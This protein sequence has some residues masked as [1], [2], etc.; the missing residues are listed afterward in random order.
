MNSSAS[1]GGH[2]TSTT[3]LASRGGRSGQRQKH[4]KPLTLAGISGPLHEPG[5][6]SD[7]HAFSLLSASPWVLK[8]ASSS[9][10][11]LDTVRGTLDESCVPATGGFFDDNS[12]TDSIH[13]ELLGRSASSH[14]LNHEGENHSIV[15]DN[16]SPAV[17]NLH[18]RYRST[19]SWI[20]LTEISMNNSR[21]KYNDETHWMIEDLQNEV[22]K[23]SVQIDQLIKQNKDG[24]I[25][26]RMSTL[27][28]RQ[29]S[30]Q[31]KMSILD[32]CFGSNSGL[33]S[34]SL[35][36][37]K[38]LL[39]SA[40]S[41]NQQNQRSSTT[42][43]AT[44]STPSVPTPDSPKAPLSIVPSPLLPPG[45][46][47]ST[48]TQFCGRD[49]SSLVGALAESTESNIQSN[50]SSELD[51]FVRASFVS[52]S[53]LGERLAKI[54]CSVNVKMKQMSETVNN[55]QKQMSEAI[56]EIKRNM[57]V[58][59][60]KMSGFRSDLKY[61][62]NERKGHAK[63]H[64]LSLK[65][66]GKHSYVLEASSEHELLLK[67]N[68]ENGVLT[69][70][71][72]K[73]SEKVGLCLPT[74]PN[75]DSPL[76]LKEV[77]KHMYVLTQSEA[78]AVASPYMRMQSPRGQAIDAYKDHMS[79]YQS[80]YQQ[81]NYHN[82]PPQVYPNPHTSAISAYNPYSNYSRYSSN[83]SHYQQRTPDIHKM[84]WPSEGSNG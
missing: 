84:Q 70:T 58:L 21:N 45:S 15:E 53:E 17:G 73:L 12:A 69:E 44:T 42:N 41:A 7:T 78:A 67:A 16:S 37:L 30:I 29:S 46:M 27:E 80:Y 31:S 3:S 24:R 52:N 13:I 34:K 77:G 76:D 47:Q 72:R 36:P 82:C 62:V 60:G 81:M 23:M 9:V 25:G 26:E 32:S 2:S 19:D 35:K 51:N 50:V 79:P 28:G 61:A 63:S 64:Q 8:P 40:K 68:A 33:W 74:H 39:E 22:K 66:V 48:N 11:S 5:G 6:D 71:L 55:V 57:E 10:E 83:F 56:E 20:T 59:E 49:H 14:Q 54:S 4:N 18:D 38:V 43:V 75:D 65:R 1:R